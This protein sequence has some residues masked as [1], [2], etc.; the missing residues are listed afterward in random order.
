MTAIGSVP[1]TSQEP[2]PQRGLV[3]RVR[4]WMPAPVQVRAA[5]A[6]IHT[7]AWWHGVRTFVAADT[8]Q[9][10]RLRAADELRE[11]R[12]QR[13]DLMR[14]AL[15]EHRERQHQRRRGPLDEGASR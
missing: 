6:V 2:G 13:E 3:R 12:S 4:S 8:R 5:E 7:A 14:S 1:M 9:R 10:A 15:R 11:T